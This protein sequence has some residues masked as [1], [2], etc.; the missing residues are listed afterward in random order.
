MLCLHV[1]CWF[2]HNLSSANLRHERI[3]HILKTFEKIQL[4]VNVTEEK[5]KD[6]QPFDL[7]CLNVYCRTLTLICRMGQ[8][9]CKYANRKP[10]LDFLF[11]GI[12]SVFLSVTLSKIFAVKYVCCLMS[13]VIFFSIWHHFQNINCSWIICITRL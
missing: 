6:L 4:L 7:K 2:F 11:H 10:I 5:K 8:G 3:S 1:Y 9:Y 12:N 13:I